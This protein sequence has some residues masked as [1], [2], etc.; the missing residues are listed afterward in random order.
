[1]AVRVAPTTE[2]PETVGGLVLTGAVAVRI[3]GVAFE[4]TVAEPSAFVAVTRTRR[5]LPE[6]DWDTTYFSV[7]APPIA[8]QSDPSGRPPDSGHRTHWKRNEVGLPVQI[9]RAAVRVSPI[10]A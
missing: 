9:P 2:F 10:R 3:N 8:A 1:L 7:V 4:A 5:R 6:S